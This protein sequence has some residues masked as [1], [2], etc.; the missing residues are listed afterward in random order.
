MAGSTTRLG[1][2]K[3]AV[4]EAYD[5][6]IFNGN[7]DL[8]DTYAKE[9]A[10]KMA[11]GLVWQKHVSTSSGAV[12][13]AIIDNIP[14]FTFKA[15]RRYRIVWDFSYLMSGNSDSLF[16]CSIGKCSTADPAA[17]LTGITVLEG[18]TKFVQIFSGASTGHTGPVTSYHLQGVADE[19]TQLK[20]RIQRVY[21]DDSITIVAN[22]NERVIY[23]IYDDGEQAGTI[24]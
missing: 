13:D 5:V 3:P 23:S 20:F 6:T 15:N 19:T 11:K 9:V 24:S 16:Y 22:G 18:R 17:Q 4:G 10:D 2:T 21:G 7:F 1:L 8:I 12:L 14:T